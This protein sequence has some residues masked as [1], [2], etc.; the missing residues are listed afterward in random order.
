MSPIHS[1]NQVCEHRLGGDYPASSVGARM[2]D[3]ALPYSSVAACWDA[4]RV[5]IGGTGQWGAES[6][7][8]RLPPILTI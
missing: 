1:L 2:R 3:A 5:W 6:G 4:Q 8:Q 7:I